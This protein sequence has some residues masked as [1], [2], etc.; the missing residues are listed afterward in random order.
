MCILK[1]NGIVSAVCVQIHL[2]DLRRWVAC[3]PTSKKRC[4]V[5]RS[6]IIQPTLTILLHCCIPVSFGR[7]FDL[8]IHCAKSGRPIIVHHQDA[9]L[10]F[11]E[12]V[13]FD[14]VYNHAAHGAA[15][16][17]VTTEVDTFLDTATMAFDMF[18]CTL[19]VTIVL[20]LA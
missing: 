5:P 10:A 20:V 9:L 6:M 3:S 11:K 15:V 12:M 16:E 1:A 19:L 14:L 8:I 7:R 2:I 18:P 13:R 17:F 4:V